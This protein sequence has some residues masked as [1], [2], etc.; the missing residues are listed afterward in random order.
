MTL[1]FVDF[2]QAKIDREAGKIVLVVVAQIPSPWSEGVK[3][4]LELQ[5]RDFSALRLD[6]RNQELH[7]WAASPSSPSLMLPGRAP[8]T[9]AREIIEALDEFERGPELVPRE[10]LVRESVLKLVEE[11]TE[12]GGLA[13][14]RR[15]LGI[16]AGLA[17][18]G[19]F[20]EP[21]AQYLGRKYVYDASQ[22]P[23][24]KERVLEILAALSLRLREQRSADSPYLFGQSVSAADVY[25]AVSMAIFSPLDE[26]QCP[27]DPMIR[28]AFEE[29]D[30]ETSAALDPVLLEHRDFIYRTH[31]ELP[32]RL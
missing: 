31:L 22:V 13:W 14:S 29:L 27:M 8:L 20:V 2:D 9:Q 1:K 26:G 11:L 16:H 4:L 19:G 17:G 23:R 32:I 12:P 15:L 30:E 24:A 7:A 3:G 10:P 21:I 25:C 18:T 6:P 28:T 5:G